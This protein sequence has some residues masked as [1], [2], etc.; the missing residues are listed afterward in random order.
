MANASHDLLWE[1]DR[2]GRLHVSEIAEKIHSASAASWR[3]RLEP[4]LQPRLLQLAAASAPGQAFS[5][6]ELALHGDGEAPR[7]ISISGIP[8]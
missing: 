7:W 5:G 2:Q 3:S 6:M 4:V 1:T 8:L